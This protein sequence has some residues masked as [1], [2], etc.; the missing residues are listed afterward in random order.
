MATD[1]G[2]ITTD[3]SVVDAGG[4]YEAQFSSTLVFG[5]SGVWYGDTPFVGTINGAP[6]ATTI[7]YTPTSGENSIFP[8]QVI[9]N[10][11]LGERCLIT[12]VNYGTNTLT[13]EANSPDDASGWSNTDALTT[14]SQTNVGQAGTFVD[15]D[16]TLVIASGSVVNGV[17]L[18]MNWVRRN[19]D[20]HFVSSHPYEA[21]DANKDFALVRAQDDTT[22][23][24]HW[25]Q[26][27]V[28]ANSRYYFTLRLFNLA[29]DNGAGLSRI[30][31]QFSQLVT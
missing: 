22:Q 28:A 1:F 14:A 10:T 7:V 13:V 23:Y 8:G 18:F 27:V 6:T 5:E 9:H 31:G 21:Y 24:A 4:V 26:G 20:D 25:V 11:T 2:K 12:A 19:A 30:M 15:I 29:A 3:M 16:V 17:A